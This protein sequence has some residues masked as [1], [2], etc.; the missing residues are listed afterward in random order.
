MLISIGFLH[1]NSC[2]YSYERLLELFPYPRSLYAVLTL[3]DGPWANVPDRDRV[4]VATRHGVLSREII[5]EWLARII[6]RVSEK[7]SVCC[8][9]VAKALRENRVDNNTWQLVIQSRGNAICGVER[10]ACHVASHAVTYALHA[11]ES[12]EFRVYYCYAGDC[13]VSVL[14]K[15]ERQSQLNDLIELVS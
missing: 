12:P 9:D 7:Y 8:A 10:L 5:I 1:D 4:W 13:A 11:N 3:R 15:S 6:V 2:C 14:G